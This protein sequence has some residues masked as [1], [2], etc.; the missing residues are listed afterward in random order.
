ML[1]VVGMV[2]A[3]ACKRS[4]ASAPE[5]SLALDA[6]VP[7]VGAEATGTTGT[8]GAERAERATGVDGGARRTQPS[9]DLRT[10][11][12]SIFPEY[13]GASI[14][15]G[16]AS[17]T[18]E[19]AP[20]TAAAFEAAMRGEGYFHR[21]DAGVGAGVDAGADLGQVFRRFGVSVQRIDERTLTAWVDIDDENVGTLLSVPKSLSTVEM[22]R[23]FPRAFAARQEWFETRL[24]YETATE[25]R[26][27]F[28]SRQLVRLLLSN[29][30]WRLDGE[31]PEGLNAR[32][33]GASNVPAPREF[34]VQLTER[35]TS[36]TIRLHRDGSHVQVV[37]RMA[38]A[39]SGG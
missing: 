3:S 4:G 35:N 8:T 13:R 25:D 9:T 38:T 7:R 32:N 6:G 12:N 17:L 22:G 24:D 2:T 5:P 37:F 11:L 10:T 1:L 19:V 39:Q 16:R 27:A 14:R 15:F 26:A 21:A 23:W 31:P 33:A 18:R 28:L 29:E 34:S 30:Q 36:A 20:V